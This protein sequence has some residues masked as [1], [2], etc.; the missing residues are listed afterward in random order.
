MWELFTHPSNLIFSICLSLMF[1]L[2]LLELILLVLGGGSQGLLDQFL[3]NDLGNTKD[4]DIALDA[5]QGWLNALLDWLFIGRVPLLVWLIIFLTL[6]SLS[7]FILQSILQTWTGRYWSAWIMAPLCLVLSM[8]MIRYSAMLI[9]KFLPQDET[10]AIYSE[11]LI[12]R[13]ALIILGEAKVNSPAQARVQDQFGQTHYVLVEP[14]IDLHFSQGQ[15]VILT[16]KTKIGFKA[17]S[18]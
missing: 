16:Q 3:P 17:I 1:L 5:D 6:Y 15:E 14:E 10:T 13:T 12:G 7:G 18:L 9:A 8:P 11:E 4:V 2:G